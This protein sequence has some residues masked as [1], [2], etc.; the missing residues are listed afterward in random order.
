MN[1]QSPPRLL[2]PVAQ[3]FRPDGASFVRL[4][5]HKGM[6][7]ASIIYEA[8]RNL[9]DSTAIRG[10]F[11][12][13]AYPLAYFPVHVRK[14]M[15]GSPGAQAIRARNVEADRKEFASFLSS[16][17]DAAYRSKVSGK[18]VV[19]ACTELRAVI[20]SHDESGREFR[21][22]EIRESLRVIARAYA[23]KNVPVKESPSQAA[24][25]RASARQ[26]KQLEGFLSMSPDT[27]RRLVAALHPGHSEKYDIGSDHAVI[28]MKLV[29]KAF[30]QAQSH[31]KLS[32]T[33]FLRRNGVSPY[34]QTFAVRWLRIS[35]PQPSLARTQLNDLPWA[36]EL[37][38]LCKRIVSE[39]RRHSRVRLSDGQEAEAYSLVYQ[40][41]VNQ[42]AF[43]LPPLPMTPVQSPVAI[44]PS[45]PVRQPGTPMKSTT[46]SGVSPREVGTPEDEV[47][48]K[49]VLSR[50]EALPLFD[51]DQDIDS[52]STVESSVKSQRDDT[53]S[54]TESLDADGSG[55]FDATEEDP[56][57]QALAV[58]LA[59]AMSGSVATID[60][61]PLPTRDSGLLDMLG[62]EALT[63]ESTIVEHSGS[64]ARTDDTQTSSS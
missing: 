54:V 24:A 17:A 42:T 7:N 52:D 64:D 40:R 59:K 37:D 50:A 55:S 15:R 60:T 45:S 9:P 28:E 51:L 3:S 18:A 5:P 20:A 31:G 25:R 23:S 1:V 16:I 2:K 38:D 43:Q 48:L 14:T 63:S 46:M 53:A 12:K 13:H 4:S 47:A 8:T 33:D 22:G 49:R 58:L 61:I 19:R 26:L 6:R 10:D 39:Y 35:T 29:L 36:S 21:V 32:F 57:D 44:S 62:A 41:G 34:L 11:D 27:F 56:A 30:H